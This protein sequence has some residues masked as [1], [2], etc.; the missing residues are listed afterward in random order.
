M[1]EETMT[2]RK[3]RLI[4]DAENAPRRMGPSG[5]ESHLPGGN[6]RFRGGARPIQDPFGVIPGT[7]GRQSLPTRL[8]PKISSSTFFSTWERGMRP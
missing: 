3:Y 6:P 1:F 4:A 7:A 8:T 5:P 2:F